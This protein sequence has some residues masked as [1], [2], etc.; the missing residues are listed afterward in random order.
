MTKRIVAILLA[1]AMVLSIC[2][3]NV[4]AADNTNPYEKVS[5]LAIEKFAPDRVDANGV[6]TFNA[7]W[8]DC[9]G[10]WIGS[11][12]TVTGY[13]SLRLVVDSVSTYCQFQ[14]FFTAEGSDA[15]VHGFAEPG[16]YDIEIDPEMAIKQVFV[17]AAEADAT[18]KISDILLRKAPVAEEPEEEDT[19]DSIVVFSNASGATNANTPALDGCD[20]AW[21]FF[22][23]IG[24][25]WGK[26]SVGK[27][28][29]EE[30]TP[31]FALDEVTFK[32]TY[33]GN[34]AGW[35]NEGVPVV[36]LNGDFDHSVPTTVKN[37]GN[38]YEATITLSSLLAKSG[39]KADDIKELSVQISTG[40]FKL[41]AVEFM[42]PSVANDTPVPNGYT[43]S[44]AFNK[45]VEKDGAMVITPAVKVFTES[46]LVTF[47][48][49]APA[50][51]VATVY[52]G[53]TSVQPDPVDCKIETVATNVGQASIYGF[54]E[55]PFAAK[56]GDVFTVH[57]E[58]T[59]SGTNP[60]AYRFYP[61]REKIDSSL[62]E[63]PYV[64]TP[65]ADGKINATVEVE[66][67]GD[68]THL[69]FK[70]GWGGD[71][72]KYTIDKVVITPP[73]TENT[74]EAV[75]VEFKRGDTFV[76]IPTE[77]FASKPITMISIAT[78]TGKLVSVDG[79]KVLENKG[80]TFGYAIQ[81]GDRLHGFLVNG[82]MI[83]MPHANT[84]GVCGICGYRHAT[85]WTYHKDV[86]T[87]AE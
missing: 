19:P 52:Y 87:D 78:K 65:D 12:S 74:A 33:G 25:T 14:I 47:A 31:L 41:Y 86:E 56:A 4:F 70:T 71:Q 76:V 69:Q 55:L 27:M 15:V 26:V 2:S 16:T 5:E 82:R 18:I 85:N 30:L 54:V 83:P 7:A 63:D 24:Q 22:N 40:D 81:L 44:K 36:V 58:G 29:V 64:L 23:V 13:D 32:V 17:Q 51:G 34:P 37:L 50:D 53:E 10:L 75:T 48:K 38:R 11:D 79:V 80:R 77:K 59:V 49:P 61:V 28:T 84:N 46:V 21:G 43:N 72:G 1:L 20:V 35:M 67:T 45:A 6:I 3:V 62:C 57:V 60:P 66:L 42:L 73:A 39:L 8:G 9:P 68:A